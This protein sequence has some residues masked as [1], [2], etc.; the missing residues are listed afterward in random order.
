MV[1]NALDTVAGGIDAAASTVSNLK[2]KS[3]ASEAAK[4]KSVTKAKVDTAKPKAGGAWWGA[5][6]TEQVTKDKVEA[7]GFLG[8]MM[9]PKA[10][11]AKVQ[12]V[13]PESKGL[14]SLFKPTPK[15][16]T[17]ETGDPKAE[18]KGLG[19]FFKSAPKKSV[20][21]E[22]PVSKPKGLGG[23]FSPKSKSKTQKV[24]VVAKKPTR[25][26][27]PTKKALESDAQP[28]GLMGGLFGS[29]S[30]QTPKQVPAVRKS[31]RGGTVGVSRKPV[32]TKLAPTKRT[33]AKSISS[34]RA[35]KL[36][37]SESA[38]PLTPQE[39]PVQGIF[40]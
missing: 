14:K 22:P 6:K 35:S 17:K 30:T 32:K 16:P 8:G 12:A 27:K 23:L 25:Q 11:P 24:K 18:S 2:A 20:V 9:T 39:G 21:P 28:R 3:E 33:K 7:K 5:K 37:K 34:A 36:S 19:S 13:K 26:P 38:S 31:Q 40:W 10:A 4:P 29:K 1:K 15:Q